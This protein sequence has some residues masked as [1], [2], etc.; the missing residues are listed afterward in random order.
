MSRYWDDMTVYSQPSAGELRAKARDS[1]KRA[2]KKGKDYEPVR[3]NTRR[4]P[5]CETWWGQAWC[6]NLERYA[7]YA[8]RIDRGKSYVRSGVVIDLN[9]S[10]GKVTAKVQGR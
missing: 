1:V 2:G 10:E 3:C 6:G 9:V 4:G 8:N 7:D 5:I